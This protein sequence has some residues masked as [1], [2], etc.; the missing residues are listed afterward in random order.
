MNFVKQYVMKL[1]IKIEIFYQ[2]KIFES[3]NR[4]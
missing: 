2:G 4:K 3:R 1:V